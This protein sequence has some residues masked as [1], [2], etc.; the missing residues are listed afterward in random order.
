MPQNRESNF[1]L[2]R[3][4]AAFAIV[5]LHV[6]ANFLKINEIGAPTNCN[7]PIM[8]LNH[9]VRFAVPC[10]LMLSGAFLLANSR[11]VDH[12]YFY[13][14]SIKN[15]GITSIIFCLLYFIYS[16]IKLVAGV[17]IFKK[18]TPDHILP[19]VFDIIK[20]F[21]KGTPYYHLWYLFTLIGL[22]LTVPFIIK[23]ANNLQ[24]GGVNLYGKITIVFLVLASVSYISSEHI[25]KW[26]IGWQICFLSYFLMG[27]KLRQWGKARKNNRAATLLILSGFVI[28]T[29]LAYINYFRG[30]K[31][32]PVDSIQYYENPFS[33]A[34]LAP[35]EVIAS[36][37]IFAGFSVLD[38]KKDFSKLAGYTFLIYLLHAGVWD[39]ISTVLGDRLIGNYFVETISVLI[40]STIVFLFSLLGAILYRKFSPFEKI[41]QKQSNSE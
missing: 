2:L 25:L 39:V 8:V 4:L 14:K 28:N 35:I 3:I 7:Y 27:Y 10:F 23:F 40:I 15:I 18:H 36:S 13:K 11:N 31:G 30:M 24:S 26:D 5:M 6:S 29:I 1:D 21:I 33:Y 12:K 20:N 16:I 34:S 9:I 41:M 22:Y 38:I 17:F 37:L 32:L 19:T